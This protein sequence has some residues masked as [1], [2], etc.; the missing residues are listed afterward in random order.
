MRFLMNS[1]I[2]MAEVR[3]DKHLHELRIWNIFEGSWK[4]LFSNEK[5]Q[6]TPDNVILSLTV[7]ETKLLK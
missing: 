4:I 3:E 7:S 1:N 2:L 6:T 5:K